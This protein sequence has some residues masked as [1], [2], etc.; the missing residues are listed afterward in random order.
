MQPRPRSRQPAIRTIMMPKDTNSYGSIFGGVILSLIDLAAAVEAERQAS[1]R[2]V[3]VAMDKVV[4]H[5]PVRVGQIVTLW[6]ETIRI[7]RT[8]LTARVQVIA[9]DRG[10]HADEEVTT[11]EVTMV[12]IDEAGQ[13][14]AIADADADADA[15][16]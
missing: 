2:F 14:V 9:R 11:A 15:D 7:G 13:P 3:T 4:F 16:E 10:A 8:S 1:R 12:A 5:C 6:A